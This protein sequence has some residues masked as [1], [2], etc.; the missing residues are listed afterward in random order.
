MIGGALGELIIRIG[1]DATALNRELAK[2]SSRVDEFAGRMVSAGTRIAAFGGIVAGAML[3]AASAVDDAFDTLRVGTGATGA[4]LQQL[5][6]DFNAVALAVPSSL[7]QTATAVTELSR[8]TGASGT[9]LQGLATQVLNLSRI[10]GTDL[11]A[12]VRNSAR[13]FGDWKIATEAQAG[14]LD[15][16]F[17]A[18]QATGIGVDQLAASVVRFGAPL[19]QMGFSFQQAATLIASFERE[20]VNA[21]AVLGSLR[22]GLATFTK[23]GL[24]AP[25]ALQTVIRKM[26]E[27]GPGAEATSLALKVFGTR[28]GPEMAAAILEGRLEIDKLLGSLTSSTETING[29]AADTADLAESLAILRNRATLALGAF[30]ESALPAFT[31]VANSA[32]GVLRGLTGALEKVS[33]ATRASVVSFT[34]WGTAIVVAINALAAMNRV[35]I[36]G[37]AGIAARIAASNAAA[38]ADIQASAA[39]VALANSQLTQMRVAV[40]ASAA[41]VSEANAQ[42]TGARS[43]IAA[44]Q[45]RNALAVATTRLA[46]ANTGLAAATA[47]AAG[48]ASQHAATLARLTATAR[49]A[50]FAMNGLRG[51]MAF[52]GGPI[53]LAI[54]AVMAAVSLGFFNMGNKAR[55]AAQRAREAADAFR[56]ALLTMDTAAA[57]AAFVN[58]MATRAT[59]VGQMRANEAATAQ[60]QAAAARLREQGV[61]LPT[62]TQE[63]LGTVTEAQ[64]AL[65]RHTEAIEHN[66]RSLAVLTRYEADYATRVKEGSDELERRRRAAAALGT[67]T[68]DLPNV[69]LSGLNGE[70]EQVTRSMEALEKFARSAKDRLLEMG[71]AMALVN[72]RSQNVGKFGSGGA[73]LSA[74]VLSVPGA[75]SAAAATLKIEAENFADTI[76]N[77]LRQGAESLKEQSV[78]ATQSAKQASD[79]LRQSIVGSFTGMLPGV[80]GDF[81]RVFG[82]IAKVRRDGG[83]TGG[84]AP[85]PG[86]A[87]FA[88]AMETLAPLFAALAVPLQALTQPLTIFGTILGEAL[89]PVIE[90]LFP[91][92]KFL[93]IVFTYAAQLIANVT[94][95]FYKVVGEVV[96][97]IGDFISKIPG[98]GQEGG[99]IERFGR[100]MVNLGK[101]L[102]DFADKMGDAR[103]KI[104][105]LTWEQATENV[106]KLGDAAASVTNAIDGFKIARY[107]FDAVSVQPGSPAPKPPP[108]AP[109]SGP[110][111]GTRPTPNTPANVTM[112]I[113]FYSTGN[114]VADYAG[115]YAQAE[116]ASLSDPAARAGFLQTWPRPV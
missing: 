72:R 67:T 13:L 102:F 28:A 78:Q 59:L 73:G 110:G 90:A 18:S 70:T 22:R 82:Q 68:P 58:S 47:L 39:S 25:A 50:A 69:D 62:S 111:G 75:I 95:A 115:L 2:S 34:L 114:A 40:A 21:D 6:A 104:E 27:L 17:R 116:R 46:A 15:F 49:V 92:V 80:L 101:G 8:R 31:A 14:T 4:A 11:N 79:Q 94:G 54:T 96:A 109:P 42:L 12:N 84:I 108:T 24:D 51:V 86:A 98:L 88:L 65:R 33:P 23:A 74:A 29:A 26:Q 3:A 53:G 63:R 100:G 9:A 43:A 1:A 36:G 64:Y 52:F 32:I 48:A 5:T 113:T 112:P 71:A 81:G 61:T 44:Q 87:A 93:A 103:E 55:E 83:D 66:R 10:T 105:D 57:E 77:K 106:K 99:A 19:R 76:A 45:A 107:R 38:R 56:N 35:V 91:V 89:V 97:A 85:L 37:I 16:L 30:A 7:G 60:L 41:A 20:G